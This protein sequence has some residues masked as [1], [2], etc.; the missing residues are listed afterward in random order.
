MTLSE[1]KILAKE[2]K[3]TVK[4]TIEE[5]LFDERRKPPSKAQYV[6]ALSKKLSEEDIR[7]FLK[8]K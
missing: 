3:I 7:V 4:G 2:Y 5:G 1:L 6:T 8:E